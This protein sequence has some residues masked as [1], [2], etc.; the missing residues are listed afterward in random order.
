MQFFIVLPTKHP[1]IGEIVGCSGWVIE[2][3]GEDK[4][5]VLW[6]RLP[7]IFDGIKLGLH[8]VRFIGFGFFC[9]VVIKTFLH[10]CLKIYARKGLL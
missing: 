10:K 6:C 9:W 7:L 1:I 3:W 2:Q 5:T 8:E 4:G